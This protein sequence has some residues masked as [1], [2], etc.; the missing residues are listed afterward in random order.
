MKKSNKFILTMLAILMSFTAVYAVAAQPGTE[1]DPLV[2]KSYVDAQIAS[3]KSAAGS[4]YAV[5]HIDPGQ[6]VTG[7]EGTE[8]IVRA[9]EATIFVEGSNGVADLTTGEDLKAGQKIALDHLL[10]IPRSDGRGIL[11]GS[12]LYIMVRGSYTVE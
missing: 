3:V 5:V 6:K 11:A 4:N 2:S 9:G 8:F 7:G 10:L 12:E 1:D